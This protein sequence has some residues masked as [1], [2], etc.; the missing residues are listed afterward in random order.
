MSEEHNQKQSTEAGND[1]ADRKTRDRAR[2]KKVALRHSTIVLA[3]LTLW[4]VADAWALSSGWLLAETVAIL[5]AIFAGT[6]IAYIAHEWGHFTGARISGA[7]SPVAKE[8]VSF[9]MFNFK[10]ELNSRGQFL[11]MSVGGPFANWGL[12]VL[13]FML[14]PLNTWS[15]AMFL[16]TTFAIAVSVS[17]F[18]F[19]V[20][21]AVMYGEKPAETINKRQRESGNTPRTV[22]IIAGAALWLLAI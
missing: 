9:F 10:D 22:G 17:V 13:T 19:P 6:V 2:L 5:N 12:F 3:A 21:N 11:S 15:Q 16:A 1:F 4:G 7:V 8:P 14:L 18:E 20:I